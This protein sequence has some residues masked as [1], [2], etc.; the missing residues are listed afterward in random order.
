MVHAFDAGGVSVFGDGLGD[1]SSDGCLL[2]TSLRETGLDIPF[3]VVSGAIG[4]E[5][6]V[7]MMKSGAH[8]YLTK[9]NLALSLIHIRC[10]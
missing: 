9:N 5:I 2:Y 1:C 7:R 4:E 6:A 3:I 8:D 10:V